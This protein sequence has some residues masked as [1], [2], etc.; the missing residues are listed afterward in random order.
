MFSFLNVFVLLRLS[1]NLLLSKFKQKLKLA[2][3]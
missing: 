2:T 3:N 1:L